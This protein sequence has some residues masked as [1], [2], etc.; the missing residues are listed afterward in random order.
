[1]R[2]EFEKRK[3]KTQMN[4][5]NG[6]HSVL[7]MKRKLNKSAEKIFIVT[8]FFLLRKRKR[9]RREREGEVLSFEKE[10]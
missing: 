1:M 2:I 4:G 7:S 9:K 3:K 6:N 10:S 5:T 8:Y